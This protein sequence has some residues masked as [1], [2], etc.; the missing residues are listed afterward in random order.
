MTAHISGCP[1]PTPVTHQHPMH[2]CVMGGLQ[3]HT[4]RAN[5]RS[6]SCSCR[7]STVTSLPN[8]TPNIRVILND[9]LGSSEQDHIK[10]H[11]ATEGRVVTRKLSCSVKECDS[12]AVRDVSRGEGHQSQR[13][14]R[15]MQDGREKLPLR[16]VSSGLAH[17]TI[18]QTGFQ[19]IVTPLSAWCRQRGYGCY[20][21]CTGT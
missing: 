10:D 4:M 15:K 17:L 2:G 16:G 8:S 14:Q 12:E 5:V 6:T 9:P 1:S 19:P 21:C 18:V 13:D 3:S 20:L 7:L 11:P